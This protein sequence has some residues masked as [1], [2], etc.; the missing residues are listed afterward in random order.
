VQVKLATHNAQ[1]VNVVPKQAVYYI[2][3]LTKIF[4]IRQGKAVELRFQPGVELNGWLE[5][6]ND[7]LKAGDKVATS[8]LD[9][10]F[11]GRAVQAN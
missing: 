7:Q 9:A 4:A 1:A 10:L 3:G 6:P 2:A 11:D 8:N 5:V